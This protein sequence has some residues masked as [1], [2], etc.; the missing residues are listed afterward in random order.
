[1]CVFVQARVVAFYAYA[2]Y[3]K[4]TG[5]IIYLYKVIIYISLRIFNCF[6]R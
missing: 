3:L 2:R 6:M 5:R 1:M 4:K